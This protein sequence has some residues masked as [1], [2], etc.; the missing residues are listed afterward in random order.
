MASIVSNVDTNKNNIETNNKNKNNNVEIKISLIK[1]HR[2]SV[3]CLAATQ[4]Y[5]LSGSADK[6]VRLWDRKTN[7]CLKAMLLKDEVNSVAFHSRKDH[8]IYATC[9]NS[10]YMFDVKNNN[11][12]NNNGPIIKIPTKYNDNATDD[13]INDLIIDS[14]GKYLICVDDNGDISMFDAMSLEVPNNKERIVGKHDNIISSIKLFPRDAFVYASGGMDS[15]LSIWSGSN[16]K[17]VNKIDVKAAATVDEEDSGNAGK[18]TSST[19]NTTQMFNPPFVNDIEYSRNGKNIAVAC[20]D[21]SIIVYN[22]KDGKYKKRFSGGHSSGVAQVVY[23]KSGRVISAGNDRMI[24]CWGDTEGE[25]KFQHPEPINKLLI[26]DSKDKK[27][28]ALLY[29][30]DSGNDITIYGSKGFI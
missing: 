2:D 12:N 10:I 11:N 20:G 4:K 14:K 21:S 13:E 24:C 8:L 30:A 1:G 27:I 3:L 22:S 18:V 19:S 25:L 17:L 6:T 7:K 15:I 29:V 9:N 5:L 28:G 23:T 16:L 26:R